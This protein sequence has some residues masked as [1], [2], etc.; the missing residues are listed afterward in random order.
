MTNHLVRPQA[1]MVAGSQRADPVSRWN[2]QE[3]DPPQCHCIE[4]GGQHQ[5]GAVEKK[6]YLIE[7]K[8]NG[9]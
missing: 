3:E 1:N 5:S 7:K 4:E 8:L 9:S 2:M 6:H